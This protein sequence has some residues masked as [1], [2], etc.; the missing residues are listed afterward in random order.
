LDLHLL[1]LDWNP[2]IAERRTTTTEHNNRHDAMPP[3]KM[4]RRRSATK[5]PEPAAKK[6]RLSE[7]EAIASA[8]A[9]APPAS[10]D[11]DFDALDLDGDWR[12][13]EDETAPLE[14]APPLKKARRAATTQKKLKTKTTTTAVVQYSRARLEKLASRAR[15]DLRKEF[16]LERDRVLTQVPS[17]IR[18]MFGQIGFG[19]FGKKDW[20]PV[21]IISPFDTG[22]VNAYAD[23][24]SMYQRVR[25]TVSS[26]SD[27]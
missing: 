17:A 12:G 18:D 22:S 4:P 20:F 24:D 13:L 10:P 3:K 15:E 7:V 25:R 21:V 1:S 6:R 9:V 26:W 5:T 16:T 14:T 8:A 19:K 23:W 11:M 2:S 27:G